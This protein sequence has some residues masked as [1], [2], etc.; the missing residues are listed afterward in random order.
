MYIGQTKKSLLSRFTAHCRKDST[1][2]KLRNAIQK[3][4]RDSFSI[5]L[6]AEITNQSAANALEVTL[7]RLYDS[8][9]SGYNIKEGALGYHNTPNL[10]AKAQPS[11][12][13]GK[14]HTAEAKK[15]MS[16]AKKGKSFSSV[17][18]FKKGV[19]SWNKGKKFPSSP[20][21]KAVIDLTTGI[22]WQSVKEAAEIYGFKVDNL[23]A[24]LR[25][26]VVNNTNLS[27]IEGI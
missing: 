16:V 8:I 9:K 11:Y 10:T 21:N 5:I 2:S 3:H 18:Q 15:L 22:I 27:Y 17:T 12:F 26:D 14:R 25:G 1:C 23:A 7:I 20:A 24:R 6:L 4:G 13:K 19:A